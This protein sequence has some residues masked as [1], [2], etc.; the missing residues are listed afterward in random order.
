MTLLKAGQHAPDFSLPDDDM[1][2]ICL[3]DFRG[4]EHLVLFFYPKD[5]TPC[6]TLEVAD[7]SDHDDDFRKLGCRVLGINR[8]DCLSHADFRDREGIALPLLSDMDGSVCKKYGVWQAR[9][10]DGQ[11]KFGIARSSFVIDRDGVV[12][13]ALYHVNYKGHARDVLRLVKELN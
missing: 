7:F 9:E 2:T 8:D 3:D 13:H 12:R 4:R 6:C 11:K 5:G 1:Q 10:V